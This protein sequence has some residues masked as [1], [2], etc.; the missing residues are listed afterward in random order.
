MATAA[1]EPEEQELDSVT[2]DDEEPESTEET[3]SR[4][5]GRPAKARQPTEGALKRMPFFDCLAALNWESGN[6]FLYGYRV[7]PW[8]G[9]KVGEHSYLFKVMEAID[10]EWLISRYG[11][12]RYN[13]K[14]NKAKDAGGD[15]GF[16][17]HNTSLRDPNR[18][19]KMENDEW[20]KDPA[21]ADWVPK[22][23]EAKPIEAQ[24][25]RA[26]LGVEELERVIGFVDK[27][28]GPKEDG[29]GHDRIVE[30]V[31]EQLG[32]AS[33]AE[34]QR[35]LEQMRAD[36]PQKTLELMKTFMELARPA[37]QENP[38]KELAA[39]LAP[40]LPKLIEKLL[41]PAP[42][43]PDQFEQFAKFAALMKDLKGDGGEGAG[44]HSNRWSFYSEIAAA[45]PDALRELNTTL[46]HLRGMREAAP[47]Q[48]QQPQR[49]QPAAGQQT[50][51]QQIEQPDENAQMFQNFLSAIAQPLVSHLQDPERDGRDFAAWLIDGYNQQTFDQLKGFGAEQ[52]KPYL[53]N[54]PALA[55]PLAALPEGVLDQFLA[56]FFEGPPEDEPDEAGEEE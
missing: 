40:V 8:A 45:M 35:M 42:A 26:G 2:G 15:Q 29:R 31:V 51:P 30:A 11:S 17:T 24:A 50:P 36:S 56:E 23:E 28:R 46:G 5:R 54:H 55:Q 38:L 43:P 19:P 3:E 39:L 53:L 18:P 1:V 9:K 4:P 52:I 49:Q 20:M 21:N 48:Q 25:A 12:G 22:R 7:A 33:E 14:L 44:A 47:A 37:P 6:W 10:E 13:L 34:R 32:K 16:R 27:V 41:Q